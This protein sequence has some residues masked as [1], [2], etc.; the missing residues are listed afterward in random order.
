MIRVSTELFQISKNEAS[1]KEKVQLELLSNLVH[2]ASQVEDGGE[3]A[4]TLD[5]LILCVESAQQQ[6]GESPLVLESLESETLTVAIQVLFTCVTSRYASEAERVRKLKAACLLC[7]CLHVS[8]KTGQAG[9]ETTLPMAVEDMAK[10]QS[11]IKEVPKSHEERLVMAGLVATFLTAKPSLTLSQFYEDSSDARDLMLQL[12]CMNA[13]KLAMHVRPKRPVIKSLSVASIADSGANS[14]TQDANAASA[15]Q[16]P[17]S[18]P[19]SMANSP[20]S[21]RRFLSQ[22]PSFAS[23]S[24]Y[25][26]DGQE[27]GMISGM[28]DV[29]Q[30]IQDLETVSAQQSDMITLA[31]KDL[32]RFCQDSCER[33]VQHTEYILGEAMTEMTRRFE[34]SLHQMPQMP[35]SSASSKGGDC[36]S[37]KAGST[38]NVGRLFEPHSSSMSVTETDESPRSKSQSQVNKLMSTD[39]STE[40]STASAQIPKQKVKFEEISRHMYK[41]QQILEAQT[42]DMLDELK[43]AMEKHFDAK[44]KK[45]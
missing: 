34:H 10:L 6:G 24:R 7:N 22:T 45:V 27:V 25:G 18:L 44:L 11:C 12:N 9:S 39:N 37:E 33:Q 36:A 41:L 26:D 16:R 29:K 15:S 30:R 42:Q 40:A 38:T 35:P 21:S 3:L 28:A 23:N 8:M 4:A 17:N 19:N 1:V 32:Y 13:V 43:D 2:R 5:E 31:I 14:P 20:K